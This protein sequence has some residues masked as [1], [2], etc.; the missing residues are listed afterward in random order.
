MSPKSYSIKRM[1]FEVKKKNYL[2]PIVYNLGKRGSTHHQNPLPNDQK[3]K[4]D[5]IERELIMSIL[6]HRKGIMHQNL[7]SHQVPNDHLN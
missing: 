1:T 3:M 2:K 7:L 5:E 6:L 4:G